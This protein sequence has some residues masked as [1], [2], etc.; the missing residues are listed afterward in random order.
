MVRIE[1]GKGKASA[2]LFFSSKDWT[3][4][5]IVSLNG[6]KADSWTE[7]FCTQLV[8]LSKTSYVDVCSL[9]ALMVSNTGL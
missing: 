7:L 9:I 3:E 4:K 6:K 1:K 8:K 5:A 2:C